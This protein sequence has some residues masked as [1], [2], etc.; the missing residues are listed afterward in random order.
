MCAR[1]GGGRGDDNGEAEN[2]TGDSFRRRVSRAGITKK[3]VLLCHLKKLI[4]GKSLCLSCK[5]TIP[6]LPSDTCG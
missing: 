5:P 2:R 6:T 1:A 4:H 3:P